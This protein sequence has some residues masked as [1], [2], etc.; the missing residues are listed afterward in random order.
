VARGRLIA[1]GAFALALFGIAPATSQ[2]ALLDANCPGPTN[3]GSS[4]VQAQTFT[5]VRTGTLVR[6]QLFVAKQPGPDFQMHILAAGPSGPT[7]GS[8][9]TT[10]IPDSSIANIP[11]PSPVSP[12][13]PADGT[14]NPGVSVTAG[15]QYAIVIT[16]P[17]GSY[18]SK[19]RS[20]DPCP[21]NEFSGTVGGSW[22]LE[23]P[24]YDF[25]FQTFVNPPNTFTIGKVKGKRVPLS[26]PGP[27]GVDIANA[28][29][30]GSKAV[31]AAKKL[32][33]S[34][35]TDAAAGGQISVP[36]RL[37]KRGKSLLR[38]KGKLKVRAAITYTPTGGEPNAQTAK[39]K[40]KRK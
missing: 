12:S 16:R 37:T 32:V 6:G 40:L 11:M 24:N 35:H 2:A 34:S 39:L 17:G 4:G 20:G 7:G 31:T 14:F 1:S 10:T 25:P 19:D 23:N 26:L 27:G 38:R 18:V 15:Q 22:S 36:I 5:A 30:G 21:G 13:A 3:A 28:G 8:L 29:G 9:G 33:K